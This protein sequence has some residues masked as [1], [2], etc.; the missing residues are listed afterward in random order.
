MTAIVYSFIRA[1]TQSSELPLIIAF[2][3]GGIVLTLTV[4]H[5]GLDYGAGIPG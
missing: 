3:L 1:T 5:F 2:S 4:V